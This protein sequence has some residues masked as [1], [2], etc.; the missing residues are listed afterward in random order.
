MSLK[1]W[2]GLPGLVAFFGMT[3]SAFTWSPARADLNE[4]LVGYWSFDEGEG[5]IAH[6]ESGQGHD[7]TIHGATWVSGVLG[8]A[9]DFDG[10]NDYVDV[11]QYTMF[12]GTQPFSICAWQKK[13][14][15]QPGE[16]MVCGNKNSSAGG[17]E[18]VVSTNVACTGVGGIDGLPG[19]NRVSGISPMNDGVWHFL[20]GIYDGQAQL[21]YVD[22]VPEGI[23]NDMFDT[24]TPSTWHMNIGRQAQGNRFY[25]DGT[26]DEVRIYDRALSI[27]EITALDALGRPPEA[28][29]GGPYDGEVG[30]PIR[31][32]A[33]ASNG[34]IAGYRWDWTDNGAWD[35]GW[36]PSPYVT[37]TYS[38]A[39]SGEVRLQV[40]D[41]YGR[42]AADTAS[43]TITG[44]TPSCVYEYDR[45][46]R[47]IGV[48][49]AQGP[50][51]IYYYD[52][53][54]N[55]ILESVTPSPENLY[56]VVDA[57][58]W[59]SGDVILDP[60]LPSY[61]P[62]GTVTIAAV[63][64]GTCEFVQWSGDDVPP[65]NEQDNPLALEPGDYVY[66]Y[67]CLTAEFSSP[68]GHMDE[69]CDENGIPDGC[70]WADCNENGMLDA[71]DILIEHGGLCDPQVADCSTDFNGNGVP[72]ECERGDLDGD[73][74]VDIDDFGLLASC[75]AG[76]GGSYVGGCSL[77]D[78]DGDEDVD[79]F[80]FA[81]FQRAFTGAA[82]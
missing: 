57:C 76:P 31:F 44:E 70:E 80:D 41:D 65:G 26:I 64:T 82:P 75:M 74:D 71:C 53:A 35:T 8:M 38:A 20:V 1:Q 4:G 46:D 54:G 72:D 14:V 12:G 15:L 9:L 33:S 17:I 30:T 42:V 61:P 43:V 63:P 52:A 58:P 39:F 56:L 62:S 77:A 5:S 40:K 78:F 10:E 67:M 28:N 6:D 48:T 60:D 51:F 68:W 32:D 19:G 69:D 81:E 23:E 47:L 13:T 66:P 37:H 21:I 73:G 27:E 29:A 24:Y 45:L 79:L 16:A 11:G 22:C 7:G 34:A 25:F 49:Y 55:R 3:L 18:L 2:T 50:A 59:G 36:L